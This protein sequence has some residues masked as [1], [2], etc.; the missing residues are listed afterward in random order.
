MSRAR[1]AHQRKPLLVWVLVPHV[2]A[3]DPTL[4]CYSDFSQSHGE[5]QRAF[6]HLELAWRWQPVTMRD[7][8]DVIDRIARDTA[9]H[10]PVVFNLCDGDEV[11]SVPG[12]SVVR[13]LDEVGLPYTGADAS[14]YHVTTSKIDMKHAFD[15][16]G[17]PTSPWS[18]VTPSTRP[19]GGLFN[20][21][22]KPLIVKPAVSAGSL[23]IS[24][25]SVVET[26]TALRTQLSTLEAGYH[27]WNLASGGVFVERFIKGPE[28]TT[29]IVGSTDAPERAT[30]YPAVERVFHDGLPATEQFLSFDRLWEVYEEESPI[31]GGEWLWEYQPAPAALQQRIAE[32]SWAAY[33]SVGG[34]G[35]GRVDLRM[36]A[37]TREL[38]V[39]EVNAQCG[40]S[41]DENYTSIGAILRFADRT[42][43]SMVREIVDGALTS[44]VA[45]PLRRRA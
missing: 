23:G 35:Y 34:R 43:A 4:A 36:D 20:R 16:A 1:K 17:V 30:I 22:G 26:V 33:A 11:N 12:I 15:A 39:L 5:F 42:F 2:E 14:F 44:H 7:Y 29:L 28:F 3:T 25:K 18:V 37:R 31:E 21:H 9:M 8:R 32:V 41:E 24:V 38:F 45:V 6:E 10:A 19:L 13:Y 27:G 40:L